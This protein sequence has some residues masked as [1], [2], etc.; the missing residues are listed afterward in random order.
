[1]FE[2]ILVNNFSELCYKGQK[3]LLDLLEENGFNMR[4]S[5]RLGFCG[6][7][8]ISICKGEVSYFQTPL[9]EEEKGSCLACSCIPKTDLEINL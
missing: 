4:Y 7:C 1:M 8:R 5:C 9:I 3:S 6:L 2:K